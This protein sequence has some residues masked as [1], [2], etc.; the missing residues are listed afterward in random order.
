M[1]HEVDETIE[2]LLP[3]GFPDFYRHVFEVMEELCRFPDQRPPWE[4]AEDNILVDD[5]SP[6][7]GFWNASLTP[8]VKKPMEAFRDNEVAQ[9][10]IMCAAQT[11]K[12]Q[13]MLCL[14]CWII[15]EDPGPTLWVTST[16]D[17]VKDLNE[18]RITPTFERSEV[19]SKLLA[20]ARTPKNDYHFQRMSLFLCG[21]NSKAALESKPIRWL[22]KDE[23]RRYPPGHSEMVNKRVRAFWNSRIADVSTA[24]EEDDAIDRSYKEGDQN[25]WHVPCMDCGELHDL[26]W[27][28][29]VWDKEIARTRP[30]DWEA[31]Y[32][33]IRYEC[34][35]CKHPHLDNARVRWHFIQNGQYVAQNP[36]APATHRSYHWNALL[37]IWVKWKDL[38]HEFVSAVHA[39]KLGDI[40]PLK[41]FVNESLGEPWEER[42]GAID[43]DERLDARKGEYSIGEPWPDAAYRFIAADKQ[44]QGGTHYW[45]VIRDYSDTMESRMVTYGRVDSDEDLDRIANTYKV[46]PDRRGV[47]CSYDWTKVLKFCKEYNWKPLRGDHVKSF[48]HTIKKGKKKGKRVRQS[49]TTSREP[50]NYGNKGKKGF[51]NVFKWSNPS[52]KDVLEEHIA[53]LIGNWTLPDNLPDEYVK[54]LT[55]EVR[56]EKKNARGQIEHYYKQIRKDNH[57]RDC[58]LEIMVMVIASGILSRA[59]EKPTD[60]QEE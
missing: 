11:G 57:L 24:G 44:A 59:A 10:A 47:D 45:Y 38:V 51:I 56:M 49:W 18:T 14:L 6:Y 2:E 5:N 29:M 23:V 25:T 30:V 27:T 21:S 53:G 33:T 36:T 37:P 58:E 7:E 52:I 48:M 4:W 28:N 55:A 20:E 43:S 40:E 31:L 22:L 41:D 3:D 19:T 50:V 34:P 16:Q 39:C 26:K 1:V 54:Q 8:W 46:H 9:I 13:L 32:E 42:M 15:C 60:S 12:T 17:Q 35:V